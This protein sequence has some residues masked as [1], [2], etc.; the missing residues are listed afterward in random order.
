[1]AFFQIL[2]S[3]SERD[4]ELKSKVRRAD[5]KI[6][7]HVRKLVLQCQKYLHLARRAYD[8]RDS[9]QFADL[10]LRYHRSLSARN[11]WQR[12]QLK[13]KAMELQRDEVRATEEF[14]SGIGAITQTILGAIRPADVQRVAHDVELAE[15]K[16]QEL[17]AT[18]AEHM[19]DRL[20]PGPQKFAF[21]EMHSQQP[22]PEM[23]IRNQ[24]ILDPAAEHDFSQLPASRLSKMSFD[25]AL[26]H[27]RSLG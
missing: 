3:K 7:L 14:L 16:A 27:Y 1:M 23:E 5:R 20:E 11:R 9:P 21:E 13:L 17:E 2:K 25:E 18:L 26:Q 4:F 15:Q 24:A 12:Y 19:H 10:A 6:D 8:L 22:P